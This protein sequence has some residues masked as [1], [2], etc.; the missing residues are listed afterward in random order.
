[1]STTMPRA[2]PKRPST[3]NASAARPSAPY[4][5]SRLAPVHTTAV[6]D[7]YWRFAVERQSI[8]M[9]RAR[10]T[11]APWT[12]DPV[13][14]RHKFTNA[15]RA[16]DR[17]SQFLISHV[18]Y[19]GC[20]EPEEVVFR[21]LLFKLFNKIET[22]QLLQDRLGELTWKR[23]DGS[24]YA[25]VLSKARATGTRIYSPAYI[26]P[27]AR[28]AFGSAEKHRNHLALVEHMM[29]SQVVN[30]V[31]KASS[32][33]A[34]Y[35]VLRSYPSL[36]PFLAFQLTIDL[37]YSPVI[38]FD[39][40]SFVVPGP[41]A[42]DGIAKCFRAGGGLS[43]VDLI[44]LVA[45]RQDIEFGS[46]GLQFERLADRR[47][48]LVDC[49]N[50]FCEVDKYARVTHPEIPGLSGRTRIKQVFQP[51]LDPLTLWFPP[52]WGVNE[53]ISKQLSRGP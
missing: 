27:S 49:Q 18:I 37:N 34:V 22:W 46:R 38:D 47:L 4:V 31:T 39:E 10:G 13:L 6:Y 20:Q 21:T 1:M 44:K 41:G 15:Y 12:T 29:R 40:M 16:A 11:P 28:S 45:D 33:G 19:D 17:V 9:R 5:F 2:T 26:M 43:E 8:L 25:S 53:A 3:R 24:R 23:F 7:S 50:L 32:L 35:A 36:G 14:R 51:K 30:Q 42:R 52:K 48:Q